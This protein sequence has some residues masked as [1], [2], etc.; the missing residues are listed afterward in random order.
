MGYETREELACT[1]AQFW[2]R[3][4]KRE[5]RGSHCLEE[6]GVVTAPA[7]A[8]IIPKGK[9]SNELVIEV[10]AQKYQQHLPV[11]RQCATL[12]ENHGLELSRKTLTDA[13]LAAGGLLQA[14]VRAQKVE[15]LAGGYVQ[16]D[17]TTMPCQ[18][19]EKTGRNHR[20]YLW[21]YSAPGGVVV[22]DFQMGRGRAGPKEFL[23]G[24]VGTVQSDGYAAYDDLGAGIVYAGCLSHARRE[25]VD[26][27][28]VA[29]LD[30]LPAEVIARL[31]ELY[32]VESEARQRALPP[33]ERLA[34]R[35]QKS[36]PVMAAL[37]ER[38]VAIRQ[39]L[40]PGGTLAK[41]CDYTLGQWSRLEVFLHD[42]RVEIDNNW[43]EGAM[44]PLVLGRKNWL[45]IGSEQAG[46][47]VA[48]IASIVETCRRLE[49]NL[50]KYLN[51][52]LPKLGAW[53]IN[54]VA[55]LTPTAWKAAQKS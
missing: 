49:I 54:R 45:H 23:R 2:V 14:V 42:G 29:P 12:A 32:A 50:R 9:L 25:F 24:F 36:A 3:V 46:P 33:A 18:T 17:E 7:P 41:A 16:A 47:K 31:A 28:K 34:L 51:D 30:P 20:A 22:F 26:A 38:L 52:V 40:A 10:L 27:A 19:P 15:L 13:I 5:K 39:Q 53:P 11:Y 1:P 37:K 4:V 21:E 55:E 35:Q 48:A 43:C 44:R 6:Q 8:Q